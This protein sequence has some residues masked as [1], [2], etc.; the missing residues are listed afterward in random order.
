MFQFSSP[1]FLSLPLEDDFV[2]VSLCYDCEVL[3]SISILL[4]SPPNPDPAP[5]YPYWLARLSF[6]FSSLRKSYVSR[7][8]CSFIPI[9]Q[10]KKQRFAEMK[11]CIF[12]EE[13]TAEGWFQYRS[14]KYPDWLIGFSK[15][16]RPMNGRRSA[17]RSKYRQFTLRE[18]PERRRRKHRRDAKLLRMRIVRLLRKKLHLR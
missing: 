3:T 14:V 15:A 6:E 11:R 2:T 18:L 13:I 17:K 4:L 5:V 8:S 10:V 9:I 1:H 16:G 7:K 12:N